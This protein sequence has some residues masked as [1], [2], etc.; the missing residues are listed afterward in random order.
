MK[1]GVLLLT[2]LAFAWGSRAQN[3]VQVSVTP[4][5]KIALGSNWAMNG[6]NINVD[7]DLTAKCITL[8]GT[9][10]TQAQKISAGAIARQNAP[11]FEV[12]NRLT[13]RVAPRAVQ[14]PTVSP[15]QNVVGLPA[16]YERAVRLLQLLAHS[17]KRGATGT[18]D[19]HKIAF[20]ASD[21]N[22]ILGLVSARGVTIVD[23]NENHGRSLV[24]S[25]AILRRDLK[26]T[27]SSA[28]DSFAYVGYMFALNTAQGS[29]LSAMPSKSG[30][31]VQ[32][33]GGHR[34]TWAFEGAG[35]LFL[36]KVEYLRV[37]AE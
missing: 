10:L 7:S 11:G 8:S 35:K 14:T 15:K 26:R 4:R 3:E 25:R 27:G 2:L 21:L 32:M 24:V 29:P 22:R 12:Q 6:S 31:V 18:F 19:E 9:V 13:V 5:I 36:R 23:I 17:Q 34:F 30:V 16:K 37:E 1:R 20:P 33:P 28:F